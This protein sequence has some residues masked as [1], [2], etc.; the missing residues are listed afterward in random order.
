MTEPQWL[1]SERLAQA[2]QLKS[3]LESAIAETEEKSLSNERTKEAL[4]ERSTAIELT[5]SEVLRQ[6]AALDQDSQH[7]E[8]EMKYR[9]E[10]WE[11][12]REREREELERLRLEALHA[13]EKTEVSCEKHPQVNTL[14]LIYAV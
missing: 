9:R 2:E 1:V 8:R 11:S 4:L 14:L 3:S 6:R 7:F 12:T 5:R 10:Q 13:Q